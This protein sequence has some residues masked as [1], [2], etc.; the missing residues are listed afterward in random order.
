[1]DSSCIHFVAKIGFLFFLASIPSMVNGLKWKLIVVFICISI[2]VAIMVIFSCLLT[3]EKCLYMP[4]AYLLTRFA[5]LVGFWAF[6]RS[7]I[8]IH[9]QLHS[10]Q[11]LSSILSVAISLCSAFP[12]LCRWFLAWWNHICL[13]LLLLPVLLGS[14]L[15]SLCLCQCLTKFPNVFLW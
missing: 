7:W 5:L 6:Y 12:L 1:M 2:M 10:L 3:L 8:L 15:R 14:Y 4:F 11:I 13:F 9:Y